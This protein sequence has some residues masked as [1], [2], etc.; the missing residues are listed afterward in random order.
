[1][2]IS[3]SGTPLSAVAGGRAL[4]ESHTDRLRRG[5]RPNREAH[6]PPPAV[7]WARCSPGPCARMPPPA[8]PTPTTP[9]H[10]THHRVTARPGEGISVVEQRSS[11]AALP[12]R[13]DPPPTAG[14]RGLVAG[15][16]ARPATAKAAGAVV[17]PR[18]AWP[19][20]PATTAPARQ[21]GANPPAASGHARSRRADPLAAPVPARSR[22]ANPL[23]APVHARSGPASALTV[24]DGAHSAAAES[25]RRHLG[26]ASG[27]RCASPYSPTT[28]RSRSTGSIVRA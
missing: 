19:T 11:A 17:S 9:R 4:L 6:P 13:T 3:C 20:S 2:V 26:P 23:A 21:T 16:T 1:M 5:W 22:R 12:E 27:G 8:H 25:P 28:S 24:S 15:V 14:R 18:S 7:V 10:P